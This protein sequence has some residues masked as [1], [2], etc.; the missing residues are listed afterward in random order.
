MQYA[1]VLYM[2]SFLVLFG[3]FY[4]SAYARRRE[5]QAHGKQLSSIPNGYVANGCANNLYNEKLLMDKRTSKKAPYPVTTN[6]ILK[7]D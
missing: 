3:D 6:G 2:A 7:Q 4:V 1:L 5:E